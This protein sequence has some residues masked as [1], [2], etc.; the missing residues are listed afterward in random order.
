[1]QYYFVV[2]IKRTSYR[3]LIFRSYKGGPAKMAWPRVP[4]PDSCYTFISRFLRGLFLDAPSKK[5]KILKWLTILIPA[6]NVLVFFSLQ[7]H[8]D[9]RCFHFPLNSL[10]TM[11]YGSKISSRNQTISKG[12]SDIYLF[13]VRLRKFAKPRSTKARKVMNECINNHLNG[14]EL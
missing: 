11:L 6:S 9:G 5:V 3:I 14:S 2:N 13:L 8:C 12:P 4:H 7:K 10:N 1:M